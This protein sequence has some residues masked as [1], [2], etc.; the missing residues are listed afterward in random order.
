LSP[1]SFTTELLLTWHQCR[2]DEAA[3][4][5]TLLIEKYLSSCSVRTP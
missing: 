2:F 4:R 5:Q 1:S 3:S